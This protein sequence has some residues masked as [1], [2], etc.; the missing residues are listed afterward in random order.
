MN[1]RRI[2]AGGLD[3][4]ALE[5]GDGN[6]DRLLLVHGFTGSKEDFEDHVDALAERGWHVV[7][8]DHRGHGQGPKPAGEGSYTMQLMAADMVAVADALGWDT[9]VLLGHSMGGMVAQHIAV[10]HL[11]RLRGLILMDTSPVCPDGI[12]PAVVELGKQAVREAG[13]EVLVQLQAEGPG[14][15][16]TP[17]SQRLLAE[18]PGWKERGENNTRNCSPDMWI[19]IITEILSQ[20]DRLESLADVAVPSLVIVGD[21]DRPFLGHSERMAK[22]LPNA[23]L[24]VIADAGHSPQVE[25]PDA[26]FAV[27]TQFLDEVRL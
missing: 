24:A 6:A 20:A 8:P 26:W 5:A 13:M 11:E 14:P 25:A 9:F 18:R 19:A 2:A 1:T 23:R 3:F 21:Q 27:L 7:A 17:A 22:T 10:G 15:L 4:E 12:D 16:D